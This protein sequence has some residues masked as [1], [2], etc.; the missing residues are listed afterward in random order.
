M[1]EDRNS[2]YSWFPSTG[3]IYVKETIQLTTGYDGQKKQKDIQAQEI[4]Q[5][6]HTMKDREGLVTEK[7]P[8]KNK[9][10][11]K[12]F[13]KIIFLKSEKMVELTLYRGLTKTSEIR[14]KICRF[15]NLPFASDGIE[16]LEKCV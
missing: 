6:S 10:Q 5:D 16:Q 9:S 11:F 8:N 3:T 7:S 4:V 14:I 2:G 12:R 15:K 13:L 1:E